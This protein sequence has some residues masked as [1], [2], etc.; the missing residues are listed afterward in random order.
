M[1]LMR[2]LNKQSSCLWLQMSYCQ[3]ALCSTPAYT[4]GT[5][6]HLHQLQPRP[7]ISPRLPTRGVTLVTPGIFVE[8]I[9]LPV[10]QAAIFLPYEYGV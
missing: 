4:N 10:P 5:S 9:S 3:L 8:E 7:R 6:L 2:D 1:A